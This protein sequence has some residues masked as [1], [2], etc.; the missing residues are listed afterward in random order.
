MS[1]IDY[2][3]IRAWGYMQGSHQ[4]Y[5]DDQVQLA[6][7]TKAPQNATYWD[8]VAKRWNTVD[9]IVDNPVGRNTRER[10]AEI[11]SKRYPEAMTP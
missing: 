2:P 9:D 1:K 8:V 6:R 10:L 3:Y 7:G 4:S 5:I 11:L